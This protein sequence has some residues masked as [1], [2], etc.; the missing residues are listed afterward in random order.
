MRKS[1]WL[2]IS[3]LIFALAPLVAG[4]GGQVIAWGDNSQGQTNVPPGLTNAI[5]IAGGLSHSLALKGD[6]TV[7]AWGDDTYGQANVPAGLSNV[8]AVAAGG[9]H[10][11]AL[12]SDGTVSAWGAGMSGSELP[13]ESGQSIVPLGLANAVA[14]T[15]GRYHSLALRADGTVTCWGDNTFG[16]TN[17]PAGLSHVV[18]IA[19]GGNFNVALRGDGSV[20][21]WGE[22]TYHQTN[23]PPG[24]GA[25]TAIATGE[26]Y[27][28]A[29]MADGRVVA[30]G[31]Q[32]NVPAGMGIPAATIISCNAGTTDTNVT[33][34]SA[35]AGGNVAVNGAGRGP[36][37]V[38]GG[39]GLAILANGNANINISNTPPIPLS[40]ISAA[41]Y[42]TAK[43]V[44]DYATQGTANTLFDFGRFIA[45]ADLTPNGYSTL[46]NNHFTNVA[47]FI[48]AA[49]NH[50]PAT[51]M[52]GI[53]TVDVRENDN[54]TSSLTVNNLPNG[55]NVRGMWLVNFIGAG[56]GSTT[57]KIVVDAA[58][59][60]NPADLSHLVAT[61]PA[62][63]TTGYPP[64][65]ADSTKN[66]VNIDISSKG[67][68][69][70]TAA[71]DLPAFVNT[72][73]VFDIHGVLNVSGVMYTPSYVEIENK[74]NATQY[75]RGAVINSYGMYLENTGTG[76][77]IFT[78]DSGRA[79][80]TI[81]ACSSNNLA[82]R[83]DGSVAGWGNGA[84]SPPGLSN[85]MEVAA[86][87]VHGLALVGS[88]PPPMVFTATALMNPKLD[89]NGFHFSLPTQNG[90]VY[91][92]EYKN[93]LADSNW[94]GLPLAAGTGAA[95]TVTDST[96]TNSQR[97]YRVT[98]W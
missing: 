35:Q 2:Q 39:N 82:L 9:Y 79:V 28:L 25:V 1:S 84:A 30:W 61:N 97:F 66:P 26:S 34:L 33:K 75:V 16:Q 73:G 50:P 36:L 23:V 46:G 96:A 6:N 60:V 76:T 22:N 58:I 4:A 48:N 38:D 19:A 55:I 69:N 86:G 65:Y 64:I 20:V 7:V 85:V 27:C 42:G 41:N 74:E 89:G 95:V 43:Q 45:V 54:A 31:S 90:K 57:T 37:V 44:P 62:T 17:V 12:R 91:R 56:W 51:P 81:S 18:A 98:R 87:A 5:A 80:A 11:L 63:Y 52:E 78:R 88:G 70:F 32:T 13:P 68:A 59:N 10:S 92:T 8:V 49:R 14:I 77:S 47:T 53:I 29:K 93:S 3:V 83:A 15:A 21:A 40:T 71:D 67:Y 72:I 24:L 94:M